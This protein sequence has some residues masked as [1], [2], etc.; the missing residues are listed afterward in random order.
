MP[1]D[2]ASAVAERAGGNPL[3]ISEAVRD[4]AERGEGAELD[5]V[6]GAVQGALQ[7][8]STGFR[9]RPGGCSASPP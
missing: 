4:Q 6:P 1:D 3:F 9:R 7:A 2:A 8:R 5:A